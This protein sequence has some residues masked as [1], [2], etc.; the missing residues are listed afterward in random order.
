MKIGPG[1]KY[2][3]YKDIPRWLFWAIDFRR[4][5]IRIGWGITGTLIGI[6][7]WPARFLYKRSWSA[8]GRF[9]KGPDELMRENKD[10]WHGMRLK[11][12]ENASIPLAW[13]RA[14]EFKKR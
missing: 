11:V 10:Y 1:Y 4:K 6:W 8:G 12:D 9:T 2:Q 3:S 7:I 5:E 14:I 13:W